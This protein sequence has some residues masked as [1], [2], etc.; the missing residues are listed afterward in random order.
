M[1]YACSLLLVALLTGGVAPAQKPDAHQQHG[2]AK[3]LASGSNAIQSTVGNIEK[4]LMQANIH[5]DASPFEK[6]LADDYS[7]FS[8]ATNTPVDKKKTVDG[9]KTGKVKFQSIGLSGDTVEVYGPA[10]AVSHGVVDVKGTINGKSIDG[11]YHY[12]RVYAKREGKWQAVWFQTTKL[13]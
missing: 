6:Y 5:G 3:A 4:G 7:G 2:T 11:R 1:K 12:S 8:G 10:L 9:F 13:P